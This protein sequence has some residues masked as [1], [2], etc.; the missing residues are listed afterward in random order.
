MSTI[1]I[2]L[3]FFLL[4]LKSFFKHYKN[5]AILTSFKTCGLVSSK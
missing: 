2:Y 1:K 4:I 5:L 3:N